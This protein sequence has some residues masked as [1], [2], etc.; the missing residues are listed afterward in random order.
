[1]TNCSFKSSLYF[2]GVF[3]KAADDKIQTSGFYFV[4]VSLSPAPLHLYLS[5]GGALSLYVLR[6]L[7]GRRSHVVESH[8]AFHVAG[9]ALLELTHHRLKTRHTT[10]KTKTHT[11]LKHNT[12]YYHDVSYYWSA[13]I[14]DIIKLPVWLN[15]TVS[16]RWTRSHPCG[17][18]LGGPSFWP[19]A[20]SVL[21][22]ETGSRSSTCLLLETPNTDTA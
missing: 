7:V 20:G 14:S 21:P 6:Q 19:S 18:G 2:S 17:A 16:D 11:A 22:S 10:L 5:G 12:N 4:S 3:L 15:E 13:V 9:G 8:H 1:M